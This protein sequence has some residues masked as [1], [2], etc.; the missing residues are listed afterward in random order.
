MG[1]SVPALL[2]DLR[3]FVQHEAKVPPGNGSL[4]CEAETTLL[5]APCVWVGDA[6]LLPGDVGVQAHVLLPPEVVGQ[7]GVVPLALADKGGLVV[8]EPQLE[9][10]CCLTNVLLDLTSTLSPSLVNK[11][12][13]LTSSLEWTH[14]SAP[15][16]VA[17]RLS[18]VLPLPY[19][20]AVV[21][22][23]VGLHVGA[24]GVAD[25]DLLGV[26]KVVQGR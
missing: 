12:L 17:A 21:G 24:G 9:S 5:A 14:C 11:T 23:D 20:L 26:E 22:L 16:A 3:P 19:Q 18:L 1:W 8:V 4:L 2:H 25:L 10:D 7:G 15:S 13:D 6:Y